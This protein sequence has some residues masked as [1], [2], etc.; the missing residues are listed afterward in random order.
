M[1][2]TLDTESFAQELRVIR[3]RRNCLLDQVSDETGI[4]KSTLSR[5]E[6]GYTPDVNTFATLCDWG[7]LIMQG[8][9]KKA[10]RK[11]SKSKK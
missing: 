4:S 8:F 7:D 9:F 1:K 3:A 11:Q 2:L 5:I 6:N 10:K